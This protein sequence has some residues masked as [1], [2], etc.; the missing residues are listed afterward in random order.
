[1]GGWEEEVEAEE[2]EALVRTSRCSGGGT[3]NAASS[4]SRSVWSVAC[5]EA[6]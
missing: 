1:M 5:A 3:P 4:A 2:E 6:P